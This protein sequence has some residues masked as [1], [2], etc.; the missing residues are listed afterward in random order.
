MSIASNIQQ[1]FAIKGTSTF[2]PFPPTQFEN[3]IHVAS[4]NLF[5]YSSHGL[6]LDIWITF[7]TRADRSWISIYNQCVIHQYRAGDH[8][9]GEEILQCCRELHSK[10]INKWQIEVIKTSE[11]CACLFARSSKG[12]DTPPLIPAVCWCV[13]STLVLLSHCPQQGCRVVLQKVPSEGS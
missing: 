12:L 1:L 11:L 5:P 3:S 13:M 9:I 8:G 6:G 7:V 10:R 2:H 4:H